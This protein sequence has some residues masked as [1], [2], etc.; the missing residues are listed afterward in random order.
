[1]GV[2]VQRVPELGTKRRR[3]YKGRIGAYVGLAIGFVIAGF[4]LY[5]MVV[6]AMDKRGGIAI[7]A[8]PPVLTPYW[9]LQFD[10]FVYA[11]TAVNF[12]RYFINSTIISTLVV[13]GTIVSSSLAGYVFAR[14]RFHW[15]DGL[16]VVMLAT[17]MVPTQVTLIPQFILFKAIGWYDH[18]LWFPLWVPSFTG[19]PLAIFLFRQYFMTMP[20]ELEDAGRIDG[21]NP[22]R[23]FWMIFLPLTKPIAAT[24]AILFFLGSWHDLLGPIVYINEPDRYTVAVGLALFEGEFIIDIPALMAASVVAIVPPVTVFFFAQNYFVRG[25][26]LTGMKG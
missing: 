11:L 26:V 14:M 2:D 3:G 5:Y 20:A 1:V 19:A 9:P 23:I 15:R 6:L 7:M 4:P 24:I 10:N 18:P 12:G 16:F 8:W 21:A 17:M 22:F 13:I 25:I